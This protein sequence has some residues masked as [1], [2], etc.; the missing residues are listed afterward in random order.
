MPRLAAASAHRFSP[1]THCKRALL[2]F[3]ASTGFAWSVGEDNGSWSSLNATLNK[4]GID[5]SV[6]ASHWTSNKMLDDDKGV[7]NAMLWLRFYRKFDNDV[8][9]YASGH[10]GVE[11][12]GEDNRD[13]N[14]LREAYVDL[15]LKR[16]DVRIGKQIIAW[17]R[18]D[19]INPTD[20]LTPRDFTLLVPEEDD[21]RFGSIALRTKLAL[22]EQY[23]VH[24]IWLPDFRP[25]HYPVPVPLGFTVEKDIPSGADNLAIKFEQ[26]GGRVDWSVSYFNGY[27]LVPDWRFKTSALPALVAQARHPKIQVLGIDG[28]TTAGLYGVRWE[29]AYT[30]TKDRDGD[31][32]EIKNPFFYGV[33]GVERMFLDN[34]NVNVQLYSR[35][36]SKYH[37]PSNLADPIVRGIAAQSAISSNQAKKNEYGVTTRISKKWW[38]DALEAEFA[39]VYSLNPD[40]YLLRPKLTYAFTDH[41]KGIIGAEYFGGDDAS[42]FGSLRDNRAVFAEVSY[43]F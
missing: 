43:W 34:L 32:P 4:F 8:G 5:G 14:R 27:D 19:R 21:N 7:E 22:G 1:W 20:N 12:L 39:A 2:L 13:R 29:L 17:G 42:F 23:S 41:F 9:V 26:S 15:R 33:L 36:V 35:Y 10:V 28:A 3:A 37:D 31:D 25:H 24:A 38:N 16:W 30:R 11:D 18:A 6:R 40:G